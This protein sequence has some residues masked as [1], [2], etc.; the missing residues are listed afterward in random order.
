[1][2]ITNYRFAMELHMVHLTYDKKIAVI[3]LL[4]DIGQS[5]PF[6]EKVSY[7]KKLNNL[8]MHAKEDC[9]YLNYYLTRH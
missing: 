8:G 7:Q 4:Y 3:G 1:M 2:H 6:L 9:V 5:N